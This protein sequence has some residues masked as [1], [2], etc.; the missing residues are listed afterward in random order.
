MAPFVKADRLLCLSQDVIITRLKA[1]FK[2][3]AQDDEKVIGELKTYFD[4]LPA[5]ILEKIAAEMLD[6]DLLMLGWFFCDYHISLNFG[7]CCG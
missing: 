4:Q 2:K 7:L 6:F 5:I 3:L 1:T